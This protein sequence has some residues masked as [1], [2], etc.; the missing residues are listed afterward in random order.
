M[1]SLKL[2]NRLLG[3]AL[4]L[5]LVFSCSAGAF[6]ASPAEITA[7]LEDTAAYLQKTVANPQVGSTG[8]E[9]AVIGLARSGYAVPQSYYQ[10]YYRNVEQYLRD[11]AGVLHGSKYTE[12]SRLIVALTAI[13]QDPAAVAGYNLLTAL[14]DY[15]K[16]IWQGL[17]GPIWALI[18]LDSGN[19]AIPPNSAAASQATR[20]MYLQRILDCEL[21]GGGFSLNGGASAASAAENLI[22]P[23]ITGMALQAL[24]KYQ[25]RAEVKAAVERALSALSKIQDAQGGFSTWGEK[26]LESCV[27][28]VVALCE[29]GLPLDDSRFVKNG[30][31]VVDALLRYYQPGQGFLHTD[32]GGG[33]SQMAT[34]QGLYALAALQRAAN[35]QNSL[36]RMDDA[37][38]LVGQLI[39]MPVGVGLPGKH[40]DISAPPLVEAGK[41]FADV[42]GAAKTAIE[43]LAS[44]GIIAGMTEHSFAPEQT[45]TRAQFAA[46]TV[47]ALGLTPQASDAFCDVAAGSWY[48]AYVGTAHAYGIAG[49]VSAD[50]FHPEGTIT[51]Q[52]AA[53][54]VARAAKL[55][56]LDTA[57]D[58]VTIRDTLAQFGDY[59][60]SADWAREALAFCYQQ[61]IL[62]DSALEIEPLQAVTRAEIATMLYQL[63]V[64]ANLI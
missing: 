24:A 30:Q 13:G 15:E 38:D 43:A 23:D 63:L 35:K 55:C 4:A 60:Q 44:R 8:G 46:I 41:T 50:S 42:S 11:C 54:M 20:E 5:I 57:L 12:Y 61:G 21:A 3:L 45:M 19:Y 28:V 34:E 58:S 40:A 17:N 47:R 37:A 59:Q 48:A 22:D 36:Y 26:N 33:N 25:S 31:S 64:E 62:A 56:G 27:Q 32:D 7:A 39:S 53:A 1:K 10:A 18:A 14:G 16:T 6:A 9:W 52:E 29:L 49:G 2:K 51:R